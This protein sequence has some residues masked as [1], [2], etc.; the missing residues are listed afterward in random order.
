MLGAQDQN[1]ID[2][3]NSIT[4]NIFNEIKNPELKGL[5]IFDLAKKVASSENIKNFQKKQI[6]LLFH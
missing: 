4:Q 5:N 6:F 2:L 3:L 1:F